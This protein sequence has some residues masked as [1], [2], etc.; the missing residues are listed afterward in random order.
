MTTSLSVF[1]KN[2]PIQKDHHFKNSTTPKFNRHRPLGKKRSK[3]NGIKL[4]KMASGLWV[5]QMLSTG[6]LEVV[7][8]DIRAAR[9]DHFG[10]RLAVLSANQHVA[11]FE[12]A[13]NNSFLVSMVHGL[14]NWNEFP[15]RLLM[16]GAF[17]RE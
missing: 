15:K 5:S 8:C 1:S 12:V 10:D 2:L 3:T 9:V 16:S 11:G 6:S 7:E 13:M 4:S 14:A 17:F